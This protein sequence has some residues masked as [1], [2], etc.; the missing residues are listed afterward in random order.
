MTTHSVN[1]TPE[2]A[3]KIRKPVEGNGGFQTLFRKLQGQLGSRG[4][5][6][7]LT[8]QDLERIERYKS[9]EPGGYEDRL[10]ALLEL[11]RQQGLSQQPED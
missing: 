6:L 11:L 3:A 2:A 7:T 1:V 5:V 8:D 4:S 10:E 9:Y